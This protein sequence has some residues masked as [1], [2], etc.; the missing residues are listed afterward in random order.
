LQTLTVAFSDEV[1][2][3]LELWELGEGCFLWGKGQA[4]PQLPWLLTLL[5][6]FP[7]KRLERAE[8]VAARQRDGELV[9]QRDA[10]E[11]ASLPT[12]SASSKQT[13][14]R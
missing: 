12:T 3:W 4:F 5:L 6:L 2:V 9:P 10:F 14:Q 11:P 1:C 8:L 13:A 7:L